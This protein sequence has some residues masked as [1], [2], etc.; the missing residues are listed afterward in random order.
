M[1]KVIKTGDHALTILDISANIIT[2]AGVLALRSAVAG[3]NE[4]RGFPYDYASR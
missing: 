1:A 2:Y 3:C 4:S